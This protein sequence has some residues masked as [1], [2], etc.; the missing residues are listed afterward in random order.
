M[1]IL[2]PLNPPIKIL[3]NKDSFFMLNLNKILEY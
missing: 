2:I 3:K 1:L